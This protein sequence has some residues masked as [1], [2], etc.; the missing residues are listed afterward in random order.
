MGALYLA[1][2]QIASGVRQVVIKEMLE[3]YDSHDPQGQAKAQR[4]FEAEAVTLA[5]LS[6]P[7]IP[8]VFDYFTE[9]GQNYIVMQFIEGQNLESGISHV[10]ERGRAVKGKPYPAE[11]VRRWGMA[12][13]KMLASLAAQNII[14]LDIKPANLIVDKSGAVWLVDFGTAKAP[15]AGAAASPPAGAAGLKKSSIFGTIGYAA[16]EQ[17]AGNP[18]ARSDVYALAATLYHLATDDDPGPHPGKFPHLSRLPSDLRLALASALA[19]DVRQRP[20]AVAFGQALQPRLTRSLGFHWQDGALSADP[21]DLVPAAAARWEEARL[22]FKDGA[23]E[24]WLGDVHRHDLA[25]RIVQLKSQV[26]DPDLGLDAFLRFLDPALPPAQLYLP[27]TV[28]DAGDIPWGAQRTLDLEIENRGGGALQ[29][30][31][32]NQPPGLRAVPDFLSVHRRQ[33]LRLV[34]DANALSPDPRPQVLPLVVDAGSAGRVRLRLR[35]TIPL[36][37]VQVEPLGLDLG[38]AYRGQALDA[39]LKVRNAGSSPFHGELICPF[40]ASAVHPTSFDCLPGSEIQ[41][42]LLVD[43]RRYRLGQ[44]N[45]EISLHARA[46]AWEQVHFIPLQLWI[47]VFHTFWKLAGPGLLWAGGCGLFG[48]FLGWFLASLTVGTGGMIASPLIG[49]LTGAF[50]GFLICI[51]PALVLGILGWLGAPSGRL[52]FR[53]GAILGAASGLLVG[54][55]SGAL[56]GWIGANAAVFGILVGFSS[57]AT[58]GALL[59][60]RVRI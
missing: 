5:N 24:N 11:D 57:A 26:A 43:T 19:L 59:Q 28:I 29:A 9:A 20:T 31:L 58:L 38:S 49:A 54:A 44:H 32:L 22:Y 1:K 14:H 12:V 50:I 37:I 52:G 36:P 46:G 8:Q 47:S 18:E 55:L 60:K 48:G 27:L 21:A 34:I 13:C 56:A 23:W 45:A 10:D 30:R 51:F 15:R 3:Y 41:V 53:L 4:R 7:G 25:A 16:P 6:I 39:G 33:A 42:S 35:F 40:P 17:A 2:E